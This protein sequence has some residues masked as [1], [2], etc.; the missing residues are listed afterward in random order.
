MI[1]SSL[2]VLFILLLAAWVFLKYY[3][4]PK[5]ELKRYREI[6]KKLNYKILEYPYKFFKPQLIM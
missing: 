6:F 2:I 3:I 1:T 4:K 5:R